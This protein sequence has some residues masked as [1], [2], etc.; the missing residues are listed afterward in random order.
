MTRQIPARAVGALVTSAIAMSGTGTY[1]IWLMRHNQIKLGVGFIG[2]FMII[3]AVYGLTVMLEREIRGA[4][5]V[6]NEPQY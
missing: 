2:A 6:E 4:K 1:A 5:E 3:S